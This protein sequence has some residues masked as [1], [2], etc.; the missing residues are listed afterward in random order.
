[1]GTMDNTLNTQLRY[2]ELY[3]LAEN[4]DAILKQASHTRPSYHRFL[5]QIVEKEYAAKEERARLAR[6]KRAKIPELL[7]METFPFHKQPRLKKK[8]VLE[9]YDS[10]RFVKDKQDLIF[11]G[12][13]GCGKTGLATAFLVH[14][15][16][17]GFRGLFVDFSDLLDTL[18]QSRGDY[19]EGKLMKKYSAYEVLLIDELGYISS[20]KE[21]ASLFFDLMRRRHQRRASIIT[22]QLGF[23]EWGGFLQDSH[24]T[25]A[26]LDRITVNCA[27]FNMKDCISIRPKKIV[28]A[29]SKQLTQETNTSPGG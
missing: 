4:W 29:T 28:Y 14:A 23:D 8:L 21:Q 26:L 24:L 20:K 2:L 18:Y 25:A 9:L 3:S 27:V 6:I 12:P 15:L 19:S 11:I 22:T 10:L 17:Q 13:T 1:M 16:N 7:V 5:T